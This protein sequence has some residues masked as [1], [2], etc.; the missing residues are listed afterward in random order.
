M[1][2]EQDKTKKRKW[3]KIE[4]KEKNWEKKFRRKGSG[5]MEKRKKREMVQEKV[6][7]KGKY[8]KVQ[9]KIRIVRRGIAEERGMQKNQNCRKLE[10]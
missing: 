6:Q 9:K 5:E 10:V 7:E 4:V 3:R 1:K 8:G 2:K